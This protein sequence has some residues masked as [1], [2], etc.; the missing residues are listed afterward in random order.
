MMRVRGNGKVP[1]PTQGVRLGRGTN[2]TMINNG[3]DAAKA[4][5]KVCAIKKPKAG[6]T[7]GY[8]LALGAEAKI[9]TDAEMRE[10]SLYM[11]PHTDACQQEYIC[12][13]LV[14]RAKYPE[15]KGL[16]P[17]L[18]AP[19]DHHFLYNAWMCGHQGNSL[20]T[21]KGSYLISP[22]QTISKWRLYSDI[23]SPTATACPDHNGVPLM[24]EIWH[25]EQDDAATIENSSVGRIKY[26]SEVKCIGTLDAT[27]RCYIFG[28]KSVTDCKAILSPFI[29]S[30]GFYDDRASALAE[31]IDHYQV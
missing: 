24:G 2:F 25:L 6:Q 10:C 30:S 27:F 17:Q 18:P 5:L 14:G 31:V 21:N 12:K 1:G 26:A 13:Q 7:T 19:P 8:V 28:H 22:G 11:R 16:V 9:I 23:T 29:I 3:N 15:P 4:F 20:I